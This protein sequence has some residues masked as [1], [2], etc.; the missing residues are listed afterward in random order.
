MRVERSAESGRCRRSPGPLRR[1][2]GAP[3]LFRHA[4]RYGPAAAAVGRRAALPRALLDAE[5]YLQAAPA[6]SVVLDRDA[7][8]QLVNDYGCAVL[9]RSR[10]ELLGRD[11]YEHAVA[12]PGR[13]RLRTAYLE[14]IRG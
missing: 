14:I 7:R 4:A 9:G 12:L 3:Q 5:L 13:E 8:V 1:A 11:W 10:D 6:F 2:V